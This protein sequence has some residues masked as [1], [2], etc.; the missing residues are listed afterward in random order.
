MIRCNFVAIDIEIINYNTMVLL[1][2]H[3]EIQL[4]R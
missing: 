3:Q 2:S 1:I 4:L